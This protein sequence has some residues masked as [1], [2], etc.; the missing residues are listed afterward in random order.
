MS[1][2]TWFLSYFENPKYLELNDI[3][4]RSK[5]YLDISSAFHKNLNFFVDISFN[6]MCDDGKVDEEEA[7]QFDGINGS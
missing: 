2:G 3:D 1:N 5:W 4:F 6:A 7:L